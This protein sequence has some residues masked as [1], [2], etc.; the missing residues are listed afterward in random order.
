MPDE[1]IHP[2]F[3]EGNDPAY[4]LSLPCL[5]LRARDL[6]GLVALHGAG[7]PPQM[8]PEL[9]E[10]YAQLIDHLDT[11]ITLPSAFDCNGGPRQFPKEDNAYQRRMDL[12]VMQRMQLKPVH[13][14]SFR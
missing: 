5:N 4:L 13:I 11:L 6:I 7:Q 2:S 14:R 9:P 1:P 12:H 3:W 8:P 10:V